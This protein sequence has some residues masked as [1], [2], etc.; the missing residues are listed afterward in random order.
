MDE[1]WIKKQWSRSDLGD[2]R[3]NKRVLQI[4]GASLKR[5]DKSLPQ[6]LQDWSSLKGAYRI[7]SSKKVSHKKLQTE[8]YQNVIK[9]ASRKRDYVLFIQDGSELIFN[10]HR[11]TFGLGPTAEVIKAN[12]PSKEIAD[13]SANATT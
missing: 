7:L 2:S 10:S 5:P 4:A 6:R 1:R 9:E 12:P 3:L 13:L 11:F 8:H